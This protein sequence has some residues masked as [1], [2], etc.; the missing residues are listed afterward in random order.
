MLGLSTW[1][2]LVVEVRNI[3]LFIYLLDG[4]ESFFLFIRDGCQDHMLLAGCPCG[5]WWLVEVIKILLFPIVLDVGVFFL[6][7]KFL[8][9]VSKWS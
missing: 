2:V 9:L 6:P 3:L 5:A 7:E 1:H 4:Y 8:L